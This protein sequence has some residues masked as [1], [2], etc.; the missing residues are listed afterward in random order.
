MHDPLVVLLALTVVILVIVIVAF[1]MVLITV[2]VMINKTL[3]K[4]QSAVDTVEDTALRSLVPLLSIKAM[5][6]DVEG[7]V[8][9]AKAWG[10]VISDKLAGSKR[11]QL[12]SRKKE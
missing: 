6:S 2:L 4:V 5:F 8:R 3:K 9:S 1:L 11:K 7:F 12:S 10:S